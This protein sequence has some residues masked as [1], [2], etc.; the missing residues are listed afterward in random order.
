MAAVLV[1]VLR[2]EVRRQKR[3]T[4]A[5]RS[6]KAAGT[7]GA[8]TLTSGA[9]LFRGMRLQS[10]PAGLLPDHPSRVIETPAIP[11]CSGN[12]RVL[13]RSTKVSNPSPSSGESGANLTFCGCEDGAGLVGDQFQAQMPSGDLKKNGGW[14][15]RTLSALTGWGR[16]QPNIGKHPW[17]PC[18]STA[19]WS[20]A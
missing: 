18:R 10:G 5:S 1:P 12:P 11:G 17:A 14:A 8:R 3:A 4:S 20:S 2:R 15:R 6:G 7:D 9:V 13:C 16:V 19:R